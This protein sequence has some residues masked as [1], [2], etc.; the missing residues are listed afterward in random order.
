MKRWKGYFALSY[1]NFELNGFSC[2]HMLKILIKCYGYTKPSNYDL[3]V[4][5]FKEHHHCY[6]LDST[7]CSTIRLFCK[8]LIYYAT[9]VL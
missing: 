9:M 8:M 6:S 1:N 5:N 2:R 4:S 7:T 3:S